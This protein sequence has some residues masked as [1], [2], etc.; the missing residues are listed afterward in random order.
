MPK[1]EK[2][3]DDTTT[4]IPL[5][6]ELLEKYLKFLKSLDSNEYNNL[7]WVLSMYLMLDTGVRMN[8]LLHIKTKNI[9]LASNSIILEHTK[10]NIKRVVFFDRLSRETLIKTMKHN[11]EYIILNYN[12][13]EPM[14]RAAIFYFMNKVFK[15]SIGIPRYMQ[16]D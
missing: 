4:F 12:K 14:N 16:I 5:S 3:P 8:E 6:D 11:N 13:D 1:F 15:M 2:L 7:S 9:D 10:N